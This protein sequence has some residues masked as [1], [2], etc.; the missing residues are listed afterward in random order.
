MV[1]VKE[2]EKQVKSADDIES[3][4]WSKWD[5]ESVVVKPVKTPLD[6]IFCVLLENVLTHEECEELI[7]MTEK[8][9]YSEAL[10]NGYGG[11]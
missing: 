7:K 11:Q 4:D 6:D 9:G 2:F 8:H 10:I 1:S 5:P 3:I